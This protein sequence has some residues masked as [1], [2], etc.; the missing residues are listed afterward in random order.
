MTKEIEEADMCVSYCFASLDGDVPV[1]QTTLNRPFFVRPFENH[2]F[3]TLRDYFDAVRD[4]VLKAGIQMAVLPFPLQEVYTRSGEI[5]G[6]TIPY[7]KYGTLYH[8]ASVDFLIHSQKFK[9]AVSTAVTVEAK[10]ALAREFDLLQRLNIRIRQRY[11][12]QAYCR[13]TAKIEKESGVETLVMMISEWF[14]RYHEWHFTR[15]EEG[16]ERVIIWDMD[17]GFRFASELERH[18]IIRQASRILTLHYDFNTYCRIFPWH[19]GAGD[20]VVRTKDGSVDVKLITARGYEPVMPPIPEKER[21][22]LR[23]MT[24][25]LLETTLKMRVDKWEGIGEPFWAASDIL[26]SVIEGFLEAL[27]IKE[28]EHPV[29]PIFVDKAVHS[30]KALGEDDIKDLFR[31]Q[32][33]KH[34]FYDPID[35]DAIRSH[36]DDHAHEVYQAIQLCPEGTS[37]HSNHL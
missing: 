8:I 9:L 10:E 14:E 36:L 7:E 33:D 23:P 32:M 24:L 11:L 17:E 15:N 18:E 27:R 26:G 21:G 30:L 6:I 13:Q 16:Q 22:S 37:L 20:F 28:S 25:F 31:F 3:M 1:D 19:H 35:Y 5:E 4:C 12:P 2:S 34:Q 29:R